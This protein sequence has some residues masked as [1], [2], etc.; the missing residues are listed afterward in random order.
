MVE[1]CGGG[2]LSTRFAVRFTPP[3]SVAAASA[4]AVTYMTE[5]LTRLVNGWP[6]DRIDELMPWCWIPKRDA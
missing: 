5:L 1:F 4:S 6:Q 2:Q 3:H